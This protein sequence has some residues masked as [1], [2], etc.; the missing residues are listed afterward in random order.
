VTNRSHAAWPRLFRIA[1]S[2]IDQ[3]NDKRKVI[4]SWTFGGGTAM[5][6]Q[7]GHRESRDVDI[8]LSDPQL[9]SFLNPE[10]HD[11]RFEIRPDACIPDGTRSLKLVFSIGE[12]DFIVAPSL[13]S[14]PIRTENVGGIDVALETIPEIIAKKIYYRGGNLKPRDIFDIAAAGKNG[15]E[16][17]VVALRDYREN[18][19]QALAAIRKLNPGFVNTAIATRDQGS[20]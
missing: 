14:N 1:S 10:T 12:I 6:L 9:L 7:I 4:D 2:L 20:I 5:M 13:T 3:V 18:V 11:F 16:A 19:Q 17:L 15:A 8:F